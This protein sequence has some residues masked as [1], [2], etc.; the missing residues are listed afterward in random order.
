MQVGIAEDAD[1]D[2]WEAFVAQQPEATFF[3]Q[4]GWRQVVAHGLGHRPHYLIARAGSEVAGVLPLAE[5]RSWMFG[6]RLISLP[7]CVYG[8]VVAASAAARAA[9]LQAACRLAERLAVQTLELRQLTAVAEDWPTSRLYVTFRRRLAASD[10]EN[11][12]AIPRKQR[13]MVRKGIAAGL[14]S[15]VTRDL[16]R[17]FPIYAESVRNLGSPVFPRRYF[18]ELLAVFGEQVDITLVRHGS[19][20]IAAVLSF[21]HRDE[22]LPYYGG[23]RPGAREV[24]GNDFMYW[25]LMRRACARGVT[26]YDFGRSKIDSGAYAFKKNWGF[27]PQSLPYQHYL[28]RAQAIPQINPNNPKYRYFIALWK[29]L[30][31]S[32]ANRVGPILARHL[33]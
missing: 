9:L 8:G 19:L 24:K 13:A 31:L 6:H 10:E 16:G 14:D 18:A 12:A 21:W 15:E 2:R 22:V 32:L 26:S 7:G 29:R 23:S 3:H 20:D 28:V 30:P 27:V 4:F 33:G 5:V 11:L 17:F 1:R 25:E